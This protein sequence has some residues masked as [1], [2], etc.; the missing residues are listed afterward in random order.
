MLTLCELVVNSMIF[1]RKIASKKR[2]MR[3]LLLFLASIVN[4]FF[5]C[6]RF[7]FVETYAILILIGARNCLLTNRWAWFGHVTR[8]TA[9]AFSSLARSTFVCAWSSYRDFSHGFLTLLLSLS[10]TLSFYLAL[11]RVYRKHFWYQTRCYSVW[12]S[13][14]KEIMVKKDH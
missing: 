4:S 10:L 3:I 7:W 9:H 1:L 12:I 5:S 13:L 11:F 2:I 14:I 6:S 8:V